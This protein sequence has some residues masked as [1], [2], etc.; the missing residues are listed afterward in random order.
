MACENTN[1]SGELDDDLVTEVTASP[2][3]IN[4]NAFAPKDLPANANDTQL[5]KFAW[6]EFI[7]LNWKASFTQNRLRDFPDTMWNFGTDNAPSPDLVVWETYAHRSELRPYN[8]TIQPFDDR[9]HYNFGAPIIQGTNSSGQPASNFLF[10][11]LDENNEIG[12]CDLYAHVDQYKEENMV[13][14][15]AKCNRD[16]YDY[17]MDNYN[18]KAALV[19][20]TTNIFGLGLL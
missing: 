6:E 3:D 19:G 2:F 9:A 12:C 11:N 17:I 13:L 8:D 14:Y 4:F 20:A 15:Q 7:A 10:N 18:T 1:N 16:E 5:V